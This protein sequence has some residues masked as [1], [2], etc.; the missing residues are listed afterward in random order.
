MNIKLKAILIDGMNLCYRHFYIRKKDKKSYNGDL[1]IGL[2]DGFFTT[3]RFMRKRYPHHLIYVLWDSKTYKRY[4]LKPDYKKKVYKDAE[5]KKQKL[6]DKQELNDLLPILKKM[7]TADGIHQLIADGYEA[8]DVADHM[9]DVLL[10]RGSNDIILWTGDRD[11]AQLIQDN[12]TWVNTG[13]RNLT[14]TERTYED[15]FGYPP[16]GIPV[17]KSLTG[18]KSDNIRG[19]PRFPK[20][21]AAKLASRITSI[22]SFFYDRALL[23]DIPEKWRFEIASYTQD[24][25]TNFQ[26][27]S[28][29]KN[30]TNVELTAGV[31]DSELL[32]SYFVEHGLTQKPMSKLEIFHMKREKWREKNKEKTNTKQET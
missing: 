31:P 25:R 15:H 32:E 6:A 14:F 20:L 29:F 1:F 30:I 27:V 9:V 22:E 10:A 4:S 13:R 26:L 11:W 5:T 23:N 3:I 7:L 28:L 8:D 12:V 24:L 21:L 2:F 18:D 17:Y 16:K 19:V